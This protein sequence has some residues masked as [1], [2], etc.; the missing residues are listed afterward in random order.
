MNRNCAGSS[1]TGRRA[2]CL[3]SEPDPQ[4]CWNFRVRGLWLIHFRVEWESLARIIRRGDIVNK[5]RPTLTLGTVVAAV[6]SAGLLTA[7]GLCIPYTD[8]NPGARTDHGRFD[9]GQAQQGF[10]ANRSHDIGQ[11]RAGDA[12]RPGNNASN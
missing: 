3:R 1:S 11:R 6:A 7:I 2:I 5:S 4:N 8:R 12:S 9:T 10:G